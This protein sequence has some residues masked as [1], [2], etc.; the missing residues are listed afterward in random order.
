MWE[1]ISN[2]KRSAVLPMHSLIPNV[3]NIQAWE[4]GVAR[5]LQSISKWRCHC[6]TRKPESNVLFTSHKANI[7]INSYCLA[8][9][10][11]LKPVLT[12]DQECLSLWK[13]ESSFP[14]RYQRQL[15]LRSEQ[16]P[17]AP[18]IHTHSWPAAACLQGTSSQQLRGF[19]FWA[20][21]AELFITDC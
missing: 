7:L 16:G 20:P 13:Q 9:K 8:E 4:A 21:C 5:F 12:G 17:E 3:S 15:L 11:E 1:K 10:G 18:A 2:S 19:P 14:S 6:L